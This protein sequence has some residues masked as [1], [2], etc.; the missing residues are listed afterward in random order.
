M[1]NL[2]IVESP[3]K[4]KTISKFLGKDYKVLSSFGHIR[5]LPKSKLGVDVEH[6]FEPT[7]LVPTKSKKAVADLK[8]AAKEAEM[9][10]LATDEDREGEAIAWHV[11]Q[12]LNL[13]P[14]K[15]KRVTFHEITREAIEKAVKNPRDID[16]HLV[17]AQQ[18]RRILDRLVGYELSPFLWQKI[19]Y[20]L[21]AG[22]VQ[23]VAMR[24]IVERERE[25]RAFSI[26]EYWTIDGEFQKDTLAF[27]A[28]LIILNGTKVEKMDLKT[29]EQAEN[30]VQQLT[31]AQARVGS[32]EKK[33]TKKAPPTPYTTSTL[34]IDANTK[35]GFSAKQTMRL[36]QE[37][38]ETGRIT[39]MRTDSLNLAE[40][41]LE[42]AQQYI[43][44]TF[45]EKY[46]E[47]PKRYKTKKKGAQEAHEAIRPTDVHLTPA[48]IK[49][50]LEPRA[51]KLYN[52]I[53]NRTVASQL[54]SAEVNRTSVDITVHTSVFRASGSSVA[55]DGFMKVYQSTKEKLL[56]DLVE[57]ESVETNSIVCEQHFTEPPAR[58]S[59]ASLVK[60]LEEFGIGRPSTYAPTISTII[61][62]GYVER[63]DHK[64]LAPTDIALIVNDVL[65]EHFRQI[66]DYEFTAIMENTLDEIAEGKVEWVPTLESFY[67]PFHKNLQE[68]SKLLNR[69]DIMP[70]RILGIDPQT[71][72]PI[73]VKTG[74]FGGFV[75]VGEYTK[76]D[77]EEGKPKPK[78]A[79]LL[80]GMNIESLTLAQAL[81]CLSLPR[82][83]GVTE[84]GEKIMA[85][86]G[87]FG[88][89][90]KAGDV[91]ASLKEP[92][93][94]IHIDEATA[95]IILKESAELKKKMVTPIAEFGKDPISDGEI[96]LK[97]GRFGP[98]LTD[99]TTN[100]S[101]GR[102]LT[103]ES[104]TKESAIELLAKKRM[105]E[106]KYKKPTPAKK[107]SA[108]K[109][110]T[111]KPSK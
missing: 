89:Y 54:P 29:K 105:Q 64:K 28:K 41:F 8:K 20:G 86:L 108:K 51:W 37:L 2:L 107:P 102:K 36:A 78:S 46:V 55:F 30:V 23:S 80:K 26:E 4:A 61:D 85:A 60:A 17:D 38:Y 110:P 99:G 1:S 9:V 49:N 82:E 32:V 96:L 74:R 98:Y 14:K 62:R 101:L 12:A 53:W 42:E 63:D 52:L 77:K 35:L 103:P 76:E 13:D 43:R 7:Y 92:Y 57:S 72:L 71:Q 16:E 31:G 83:V 50:E 25:R 67:A 3:T 91:T 24:L 68:K 58:Y 22:R 111:K 34:Q 73:S 84:Q 81:E 97:H 11:A 56:P 106:T 79:S 21:S 33:L 94:P 45:G 44:S 39:Y 40:K 95:R 59:D 93:D 15:Y 100:A 88:P 65:V 75:Q 69:E 6:G 70:D 10:Y 48:N 18:A 66:V 47:G 104:L 27:P 90:L 87:R 19:R 109:K 5:D